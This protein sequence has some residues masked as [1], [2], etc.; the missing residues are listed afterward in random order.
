MLR[1]DCRHRL[2]LTVAGASRAERKPYG[3]RLQTTLPC[4]EVIRALSSVPRKPREASSKSLVSANGSAFSVAACCATTE[5][6]ASLG[7]SLLPVWVI[8]PFSPALVAKIRKDHRRFRRRLC[9]PDLQEPGP[10]FQR[11]GCRSHQAAPS[12]IRRRMDDDSNRLPSCTKTSGAC[13]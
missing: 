8:L 13:S 12:T 3:S 2:G 7:A 10:L 6:D 11:L 5:P 1:R 9:T 4:A